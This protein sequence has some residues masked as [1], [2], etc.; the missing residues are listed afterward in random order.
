MLDPVA[1]VALWPE[2]LDRAHEVGLLEPAGRPPA[3]V[4][5]ERLDVCRLMREVGLEAL[6]RGGDRGD[7]LVEAGAIVDGEID[8]AVGLLGD[9]QLLH[10]GLQLPPGRIV[11]GGRVRE[12][13]GAAEAR[14]GGPVGE[15][16]P[17]RL[18]VELADA[19][20]AEQVRVGQHDDPPLAVLH[21]RRERGAGRRSRVVGASDRAGAVVQRQRPGAIEACAVHPR[22][23]VDA[24]VPVGGVAELGEHPGRRLAVVLVVLHGA[25]LDGDPEPRQEL[26]QVVAVLVLLGLGEDDQATA[27]A[28]EL[29]DR[30]ELVAREAR[31]VAVRRRLPLRLGGM[32]DD[33][34]VGVVEHVGQRPVGVGG[35]GEVVG[36]EGRRRARVRGVL[37]V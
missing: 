21:H 15:V 6:R 2:G 20:V 12:R 8:R 7:Q 19:V 13:V 36:V 5:A 4:L 18:V 32:G 28:H 34:H 35:D 16:D 23:Q 26:V 29:V 3:Q 10:R 9:P 27:A 33:E 31:G 37:G 17:Q 1:A 11:L 22:Q 24:G 14:L 25:A 30:V